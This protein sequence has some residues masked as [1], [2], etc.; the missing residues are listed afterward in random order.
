MKCDNATNRQMGKTEYPNN[1]QLRNEEEKN[2]PNVNPIPQCVI[3]KV[4]YHNYLK[5]DI[6]CLR[7]QNRIQNTSNDPTIKYKSCCIFL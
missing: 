1:M 7:Q 6:K 3:L 5:N 4:I 2:F